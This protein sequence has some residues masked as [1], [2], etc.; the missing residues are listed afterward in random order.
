[1]RQVL[2]WAVEHDPPA[3]LRLAVALAWWWLLRGRL[4]GQYRLLRQVAGHAEPGRDAW[5]AAQLWLGY[6]AQY[7]ADLAGALGH[8]TAI[9][10][11]AGDR[12]P[13]PALA[14]ALA[15]R[16]VTLR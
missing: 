7:S 6:A 4:A 11:A 12:P 14:D 5:Y 13:S 1:M 2:A 8:F 16:S 15:G 3:A 10:D 9:R